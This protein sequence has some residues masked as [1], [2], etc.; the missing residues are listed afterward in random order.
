[1]LGRCARPLWAGH[2][3]W[4]GCAHGALTRGRRNPLR[5]L[6][7][8]PTRGRHDLLRPSL[9]TPCPPGPYPFPINAKVEGAYP[10]CSPSVC[11]GDRH[12]LVRDN[13]TCE[14]V[15]HMEW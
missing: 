4:P 1:M 8:P 10:G 2:T 7:A 15:S 3:W 9:P 6:P 5:T 12:V 13:N 14:R 11:S